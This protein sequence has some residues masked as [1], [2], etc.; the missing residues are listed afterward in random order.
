MAAEASAARER[1]RSMRCA[2]PQVRL[3]AGGPKRGEVDGLDVTRRG[4]ARRSIIQ[5]TVES[6]DGPSSPFG[7]V[8]I[9]V[10]QYTGHIDTC[11]YR[12]SPICCGHGTTR[13]P[14]SPLDPDI[15]LLTALADPTRLAHRPPARR[16]HRDVR[17]RLHRLLR[18]RPA[19]RLASPA[20][21]ARGGDR[22]VG[23][24]WPVDLL[25]SR[26]PRWPAGWPRSP[27]TLVPGGLISASD[28][29]Q[30]APDRAGRRRP[31]LRRGRRP[32]RA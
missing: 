7:R 29:A 4:C 13:R 3:E 22:D 8:G 26:D 25:S 21:P 24:T 16:G 30:R 14:P 19:D 11:Q 28:A 6:C 17:L 2:G 27:R 1:K 15:R 5:A 23:A 12:N 18:R 20:R 32:G 9:D 10:H 31:S